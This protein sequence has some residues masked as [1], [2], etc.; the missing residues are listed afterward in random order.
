MLDKETVFVPTARTPDGRN[1]GDVEPQCSCRWRNRLCRGRFADQGRRMHR[2][3][4]AAFMAFNGSAK[5]FL[6]YLTRRDA[7]RAMGEDW[8]KS[9]LWK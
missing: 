7:V 9:T 3:S 2:E 8:H 4:L 6:S 1:A 5:V